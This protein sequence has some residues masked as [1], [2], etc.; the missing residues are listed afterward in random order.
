VINYGSG[1]TAA[2]I[3]LNGNAALNGTRLRLT[4]TTPT[5]QKGTA[6]FTTAVNVQS[7]TT[8]FSFQLTTPNADGMAFVLQ[9]TGITALGTGGGYLGYGGIANSLAVKFDLYNNNGEGTNSTGMY[10]GGAA[11]FTPALDLTSSGVNLHSGDVFNVHMSYDG[12][13]LTMSITDATTAATFSTSWPVNIPTAV[14]GNTAFV[15]F[16]GGTGGL[17]ATQEVL[18]WTY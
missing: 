1:F 13:T 2:G 7:F 18:T 17:T 9:N 10:T 8:D 12:T 5:N 14:G 6:F 4:T 11:P 15:G 16:T 3:K